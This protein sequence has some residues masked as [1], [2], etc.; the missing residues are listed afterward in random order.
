MAAT[1]ITAT[2]TTVITATFT[3]AMTMA[4]CDRDCYDYNRCGDGAGDEDG[5]D[6]REREEHL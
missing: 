1:V 3:V 2:F 5:C 6:G 4:G